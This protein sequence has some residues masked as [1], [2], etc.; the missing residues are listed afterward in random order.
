MAGKEGAD[1]PGGPGAPGLT[2]LDSALTAALA[3]AEALAVEKE[4]KAQRELVQQRLAQREASGEAAESGVDIRGMTI[5]QVAELRSKVPTDAAVQPGVAAEPGARPALTVPPLDLRERARLAAQGAMSSGAPFPRRSPPQGPAE[6]SG[7]APA[8]AEE[9]FQLRQAQAE[10]ERQERQLNQLRADLNANRQRYQRLSDR[11]ADLQARHQRLELEL[12]RRVTSQVLKSLLP[13]LDAQ[14]AVVSSLLE[15][16]DLQPDMRVGL[17]MLRQEWNR[18]LQAVGVQAFDAR[19]QR[20]DPVVHEAISE[21][22]G[23]GVDEGEVVRQ[24]GRGYL[25][26]GKL[27]RSAQVVVATSPVRRR[28]S[29]SK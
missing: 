11:H 23:A 8:T 1:Q 19:G 9:R 24:A 2:S 3:E 4:R 10:L 6:E 7:A 29:S 14:E 22:S 15:R 17:E 12:P 26:E 5:E 18:A 21:E 27:L 25:L 13:A 16:E 20:F 28:R